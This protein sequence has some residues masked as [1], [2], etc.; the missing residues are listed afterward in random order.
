MVTPPPSSSLSPTA[1]ATSFVVISPTRIED[2]TALNALYRPGPIQGGMIDD[3]INRKHG[4]TKVAY[5]L[6]QLQNILEEAYG[7]ILYQGS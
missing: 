4:K 7:V 1:C 2:L 3:F 6:P 5:E